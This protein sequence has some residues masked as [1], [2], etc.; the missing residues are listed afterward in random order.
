M[1]VG[2]V[3]TR[4]EM[5]SSFTNSLQVDLGTYDLKTILPQCFLLMDLMEKRHTIKL[6]QIGAASH[7]IAKIAADNQIALKSQIASG[8]TLYKLLKS[9]SCLLLIVSG[10]EATKIQKFYLTKVVSILS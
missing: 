8:V 1:G 3:E 10:S 4:E 6:K 7:R 5:C 9:F 2:L